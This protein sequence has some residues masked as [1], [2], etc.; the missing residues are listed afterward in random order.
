MTGTEQEP[1]DTCRAQH[2]P[3]VGTD[4]VLRLHWS[5]GFQMV[6]Q[7]HEQWLC[8]EQVRVTPGH[9]KCSSTGGGV[10]QKATFP[11]LPQTLL[12][13]FKVRPGENH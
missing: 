13:V 2:S 4:S 9:G 7:V 5:S 3:S 8:S 10:G 6:S 12:L 11:A 1:R